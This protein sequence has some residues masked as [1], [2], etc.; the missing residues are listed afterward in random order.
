MEHAFRD[1]AML[2]VALGVG[3]GP[4]AA[5]VALLNRRDRRA[6]DLL[7]RVSAQFS[8]VALRSDVAIGVRCAVLG[9]RARVTVD[10][11][12]CS[13]DAIWEA[14]SRLRRALP[15]RVAVRVV[16]RLDT[17]PSRCLA[18]RGAGTDRRLAAFEVRATAA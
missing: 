14:L 2:L 15:L 5:L 8:G 13:P 17:E 4:I 10:M 12:A 18:A 6:T 11:R 16:S 7:I 3:T 1:V 9:R